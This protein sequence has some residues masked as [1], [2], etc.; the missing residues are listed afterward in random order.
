M[1]ILFKVFQ[2]CFDLLLAPKNWE[3][4]LKFTFPVSL[5]K[6]EGLATPVL[7][8]MAVVKCPLEKKL[9]TPK[10][11]HTVLIMPVPRSSGQS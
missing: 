7:L 8:S 11:A 1:L 9:S 10:Y 2:K 6:S 4:S 3:I 5:E